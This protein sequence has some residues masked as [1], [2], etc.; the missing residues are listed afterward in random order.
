MI[1]D[2]RYRINPGYRMQDSR[3]MIYLELTL[4]STGLCGFLLL[5]SAIQQVPS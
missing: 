1:H 5:L 3:F 2:A 4:P